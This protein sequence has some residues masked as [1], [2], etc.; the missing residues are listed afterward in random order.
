MSI[1]SVLEASIGR[2]LLIRI[3]AHGILL[4]A[5]VIATIL[6]ARWVMSDVEQFHALRAHPYLAAAV[7]ERVLQ[8]GDDPVALAKELELAATETSLA[9]S[10][11]KAD[12]ALLASSIEPP[13]SMPGA[14]EREAIVA[15]ARVAWASER[16]VI[17]GFDGERLRTIAVV[18]APLARSVPWHVA[19]LLGSAV[20]LAFVFVAAP[21]THSIA[22]PIERLGALARELGAGNLAVRAPTDRRD[23]IGDLAR[24][25]NTM[26]AQIQR[27]RAAERELL[28]DVSHEL[29]TPLARMRVVLELASNADLDRVHRY[30][31]EVTSDLEELERL[32]DDIIVSS[33]LDPESTQWVEA[34][35]PLRR[36]PVA[37]QA[38]VDAG[39]QRFRASH[40]GRVLEVERPSQ[41]LVVDGDFAMLRRVLDNL[42]DNARKY[43]AEETPIA[44]RV[45]QQD[46]RVRIEV[47]DQGVGIPTEDQPRVF[48]PFYRAD[49]SRA[50]ASGGVG[51]GLVLARR[52]VEAH[53]GSIGFESEIDRGS[54]F[55]FALDLAA[56]G[57]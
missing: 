13:L 39:A 32:I 55:W 28:G 51:L 10:I 2:R 45:E 19:G 27:L 17:G 44:V 47:I 9:L 34:R 4:F 33:R 46:A 1:R 31:A 14:A 18:R 29:R 22:R 35:P 26:A 7:A 11:Y 15:P 3:W 20:V 40:P 54:R 36:Q 42:L 8:R 37:V 52:I 12:G 6:V 16:L 49:R 50:R 5:G 23:E 48:S 21:L 43:A 25:F 41:A 38:L 53:G 56:A 24:S 57:D 30:L